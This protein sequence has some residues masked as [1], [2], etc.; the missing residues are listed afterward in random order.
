[1]K[2][3]NA[4][5]SLKAMKG[6]ARKLQA[7]H[8]METTGDVKP[9]PDLTEDERKLAA[10]FGLDQAQLQWRRSKISDL[11]MQSEFGVTALTGADGF[12]QEYPF[13]FDEA[14]DA[15]I[16]GAYYAKLMEQASQENRIGRVPH[17]PGEL[18]STAW[19]L[20]YGDTTA[21][22]FY[23]HK[24]FE[25]RLIDYYEMSGQGLD[26]YAKVLRERGYN[27]GEHAWPHDGGNG[28]LSTGKTRL[29]TFASLGFNARV[30]Q[31]DSNVADGINAVRLL[32][33]KCYFDAAKCAQG[34]EAMRQ[35]RCDF[36]ESRRIWVN[37][38]RHD[39]AS[40]G[41]DS[42]RTLARAIAKVSDSVRTQ[43]DRWSREPSYTNTSWMANG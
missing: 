10:T 12:K 31:R 27:Y 19:D 9:W 28:D 14:F 30:L 11:E 18:V 24:G 42:F 8:A 33:P 6:I 2:D 36:D 39:W 22:W 37:K 5:L 21:I 40:N 34:I 1:M 17:E 3:A 7:G 38:P 41:A 23:Q 43:R 29:Q 16:P 4:T 20:G 15:I 26:H 25:V 35:Y 32:L 13:T